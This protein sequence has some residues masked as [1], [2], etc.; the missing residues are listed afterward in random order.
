MNIQVGKSAG[1]ALLM[2]AALLAAL[3]AMGV[4]AP[5]GVDASV[6]TTPKPTAE[7]SSKDLD[8]ENVTLTV[9]FETNDDIDGAPTGD[10]VVVVV[11]SDI[12]AS[13]TEANYPAGTDKITV[14][15]DGQ[16]VGSVSV[17]AANTITITQPS[18]GGNVLRA[19]K[20]TTLTVT[21][22]TLEGT[23]ATGNVT[24]AQSA[25]ATA[26]TDR[27]VSLSIYD[28]ETAP[29]N[30]SA[31]VGSVATTL[32]VKFTP[33]ADGDVTLDL[34]DKYILTAANV[35]VSSNATEAADSL[36]ANNVQTISGIEATDTEV[37]VTF[38]L[39]SNLAVGDEITI[40]QAGNFSEKIE[41]GGPAFSPRTG[42][43]APE[44]GSPGL[45]SPSS[46]ADNASK[47]GANVKVTINANAGVVINGGSNIVITLPGFGIPSSIDTDDVIIDGRMDTDPTPPSPDTRYYGNP[48]S[49]SVS[50]DKITLRVPIRNDDQAQSVTSIRATD[51]YRIIF[52]EEA[53]ITNPLTV[54]IK[55]ITVKDADPEDEKTLKA[56]IVPSVTIAP[57]G[58]FVT[59]GGDATVTAKGVRGGTTT[60]YLVKN[61]DDGD[62]MMADGEYVRGGALGS[63]TAAD[64]VAAI[65]IDTSGSNLVAGATKDGDSDKAKNTVVVIDSNNDEVG[66]AMLGIKPTVKLTSDSAERSGKLEISVSDWFYGEINMIT[67]GG[68]EVEETTGT[69]SV[70]VG[71]D[72]KETFEV[73]VPS[74]V[75]T[76]EQEL[77]LYG[78]ADLNTKSATAKVTISALALDVSPSSVVPNQQVTITGSGFANS[79]AVNSIT[80]G[81][82]T[83]TVPGDAR[84]TSSGKVAVTVPV[85]VDVGTGD[86][87]VM[88]TVGPR[89]GEGMITVAKPSITLNP[90]ES[91]PGSVISVN[92][93]GFDS[94]GR[95]EVMYGTGVEAVGQADS[96]GEF[97]IRLTVPSNAGIDAENTIKVLSRTEK[98]G[99]ISAT[100]KHRT[101]GSAIMLP[102][103]AQVGTQATISG[104]NFAVFSTLTVKIGTHTVT[105]SPAPET[106]K[107]GAFETMARVPRIPAGSHTVTVTDSIG[108]SVTETFTVILTPVV[109]TPEEVFGVLGDKLVSV[110]SLDNA[111]KKWSAYFPG[112]P[113]GVSDLTGV[114]S[115][116]IV[117]INVNADVE[118]QGGMLTTGWN[119]ISL[120]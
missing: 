61:D 40:S 54:G 49:V 11:P 1:I 108:N 21:G 57:K 23:A 67:I 56:K 112:A 101:P 106:D 58:G 115:R 27:E 74:D 98:G 71:S 46:G 38:T 47:A 89:T 55:T 117:W 32:V 113:E 109:N 95:F 107:N 110:W 5:V 8:A 105:P 88:L 14:T 76:G 81:G 78:D 90:S 72:M 92:G 37:T 39:L 34:P 104:T 62:P 43:V 77:K 70:E 69:K 48:D 26:T 91:V 51:D 18:E 86:K 102:D 82:K 60:V 35:A 103:Q 79:T 2:A 65:D 15:Q 96:G 80:I 99:D 24:V 83:V 17:T 85:P 75:R 4:F 45:L 31:T 42:S 25:E 7:L 87:K 10:N 9:T 120:E 64:G 93:S 3:F 84:S 12:T 52:F 28:A 44:S 100:A 13:V 33:R 114:S 66:M 94:S 36:A 73:T 29:T 53:G 6:K 22:L 19:H 116:D 50:G 20:K 111:T 41:V 97:S 30:I 16:T 118:F 68:I 59:R 119:L 63:G